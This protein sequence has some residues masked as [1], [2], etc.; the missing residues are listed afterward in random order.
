MWCPAHAHLETG[1]IDVL[2]DYFC[3]VAQA[4]AEALK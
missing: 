3:R 4:R 1:E 2:V